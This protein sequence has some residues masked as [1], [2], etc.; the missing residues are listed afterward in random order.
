MELRRFRSVPAF[1][2][3][4]AV[5]FLA[6]SWQA[7][8]ATA[9]EPLLPIVFVHGGSGSAAQYE[10]QAQR[11]ASNDYPN[12][13]RALD[14]FSE[15]I[16]PVDEQMDDFFDA[17]MAETGD[18]QIFVLSHSYGSLLMKDWL[19]S[20]P[21]RSAK[22]AKFISIDSSSAGE[23]PECPGNPAPVD[24]IGIYREENPNYMG[25]VTH[26]LPLHGHTQCV[27]SAESFAIQYEYLTGEE[28]KTTLVLP[29]P[30]GQVEIS[31]RVVYFPD[32]T[33]IGLPAR[34]ELWEIDG[35][36]G[37]RIASVPKKVLEIGP[38]GE[39]GPAKVHGMK[40]YEFSL[41]RSDIDI[42]THYY[43][44]RFLRDDHLIR[45][46]AS[47]ADSATWD[48]TAMSP[49]HAALVI[50]RYFEWWND[51]A[52]GNDI[53]WV[54]TTSPAWDDDPL[55]PTP[56]P[57][58]ILSNPLVAPRTDFKIGIHAHDAPFYGPDKVS[59]LTPIFPFYLMAFQTSVDIWMPA[60]EPP[61]GTITFVNEPR[62][63]ATLPQTIAIPNWASDGHRVLIQFNTYFQDIN[64]WPECKQA[65]PS[66]CN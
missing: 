17:V 16:Q 44:Q 58:N 42:I 41:Y 47:P 55:H 29:E 64:S 40:H 60:T 20:S 66:P 14:R 25:P 26:R 48:Y 11:W 18:D 31:G 43:F 57:L 24:C 13:V 51:Q 50:L 39:F 3:V 5:L 23:N 65:Q 62:G 21:E 52:S 54:T 38:N 30:P 1:V 56:P 19:N 6:G 10:N 12:V 8:P 2:P 49:D 9:D 63:D 46:L 45:L 32:N 61:D 53:L 34:L 28:A 59:T 37:A 22:V 7:T 27:T 35:D 33:P 4:L 36:T 15:T